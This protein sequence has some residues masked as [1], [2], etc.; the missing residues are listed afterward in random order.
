[1]PSEIQIPKIFGSLR[2]KKRYKIYYGG[3]GGGKSE[4]IA[5]QLLLD[6]IEKPLNILCCREFM[7]SIK[8][9]VHAL[10]ASIINEN[11]TLSN[12]Y[13][14][15]NTEIRGKN[16]TVFLF[17]GVRNNIANIKSINNIGKCWVEEAETVSSYSWDTLIPSIRGDDSEIIISFNPDSDDSP[18]YLRFVVNPPEDSIVQKITYRD[19]P[20]FPDV[21]RKEMEEMKKKDP[22][23]YEWIWEG[24]CKPAVQGAV[25][26]KQLQKA[27]DEGRVNDK[28]EYDPSVPVNT[29]WDLGKRD[30]TAIWFCQ[31]VG[32]QW[33]IINHYACNFQ[34]LEHYTDYIQSLPYKYGAHFLPHDARQNRLGMQR[35]V[36]NQVQSILGKVEVVDVVS[37]KVHAIEAARKIFPLCFFNSK[38]CSDGLFAMKRYKYKVDP[39]TLKISEEPD[40]DMYSHTAD[41]FLTFA[42]AG[43]PPTIYSDDYFTKNDDYYSPRLG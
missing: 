27:Y 2:E 24:N 8:D 29:Y 1:M 26:E 11:Q 6:G 16:G 43:R 15:L 25:F 30:S 37:K 32:M 41:A 12:F 19:N 34:E 36:E 28:V 42:M 40:H 4:S 31:Y 38:N 21:L 7:R 13:E 10:I 33:R 3:R 39:V 20:F 22:E 23:K 14:V 17:Y 9:S 5:R 35:T 18:T